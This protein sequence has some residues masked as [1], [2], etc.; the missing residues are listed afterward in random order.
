MGKIKYLQSADVIIFSS[1]SQMNNRRLKLS[2]QLIYTHF[3][4]KFPLRKI[5]ELFFKTPLT[6]C[7][8]C[9]KI[10]KAK[11]IFPFN[12]GFTKRKRACAE[13]FLHAFAQKYEN[14]YRI[15]LAVK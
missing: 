4:L 3:L 1:E 5:F 10:P 6:A 2:K 12:I 8:C 7:T 13:C 15:W 9:A 11:P 14:D